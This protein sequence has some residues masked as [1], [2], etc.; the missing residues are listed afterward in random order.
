MTS[1]LFRN[2]YIYI[3]DS[4][5][6]IDTFRKI[7][8]RKLTPYLKPYSFVGRCN[9]RFMLKKLNQ[10]EPDFIVLINGGILNKDIIKTAKKGVINAH[11]GL[12]PDIR[13]LDAVIHSVLRGV[14]VGVTLHLINEGIDTGDIIEK[15]II[16]I[17]SND[18]LDDILLK[19]DQLC[20]FVLTKFI[21]GLNKGI[22]FTTK[23]QSNKFPLCRKAT[24]D[25][26]KKAT[27]QISEGKA[28]SLYLNSKNNKIDAIDCQEYL[29]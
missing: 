7:K 3:R 18:N 22:E 15:Y 19:S 16:P 26:Y 9:S 29:N 10:I 1:N 8:Q 5:A 6:N 24:K 4:L 28:F 14:P 21:E 12:L 13:G 2:I 27:N 23:K 20:N 17:K 25:E 11:P